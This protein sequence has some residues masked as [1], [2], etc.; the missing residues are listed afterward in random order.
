MKSTIYISC[1]VVTAEKMNECDFITKVKGQQ[2]KPFEKIIL[3][4]NNGYKVQ[5]QDNQIAWVPSNLFESF[6]RTLSGNEN[7]LLANSLIKSNDK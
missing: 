1:E 2:L 3:K 7:S 4:K 6:F 5:Y